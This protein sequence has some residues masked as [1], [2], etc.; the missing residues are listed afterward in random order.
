MVVAL[1]TAFIGDST[2]LNVFKE[3]VPSNRC[4]SFRWFTTGL[5]LYAVLLVGITLREQ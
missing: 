2:L 5:V 4:S 1:L 3:E